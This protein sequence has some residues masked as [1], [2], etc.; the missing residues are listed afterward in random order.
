MADHDARLNHIWLGGPNF[1]LNFRTLNWV[2]LVH[3]WQDP[4]RFHDSLRLIKTHRQVRIS[5]FILT[6]LSLYKY[7]PATLSAYSFYFL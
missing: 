6:L 2:A 7:R 3:S 5:F 1:L 4:D